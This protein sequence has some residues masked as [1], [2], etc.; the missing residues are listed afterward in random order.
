MSASGEGPPDGGPATVQP[1]LFQGADP[2]ATPAQRIAAVHAFTTR[3]RAWAVDAI[4][5]RRAEGRPAEDWEAY[6]R[7]TDHTLRELENGTLDHWFVE[8]P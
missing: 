5:R 8:N 7:F 3:C 4:A 1:P 2:N 6:L